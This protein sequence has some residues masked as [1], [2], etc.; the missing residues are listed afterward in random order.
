MDN[1]AL[2]KERIQSYFS[3]PSLASLKRSSVIS[4]EE[5]E[6]LEDA[7]YRYQQ[8]IGLTFEGFNPEEIEEERQ[9]YSH[10]LLP[11]T[12]GLVTFGEKECIE[13]LSI[14]TGISQ[15]KCR[16]Y[17]HREFIN[18]IGSDVISEKSQD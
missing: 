7:Y 6:K 17:Q 4:K 14:I 9:K 10:L 12:D 15:N 5:E 3:L 13:Y 2:L 18:L 11:K 8:F 16:A 1:F